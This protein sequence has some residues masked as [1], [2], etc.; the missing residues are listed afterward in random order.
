MSK[1]L[2]DILFIIFFVIFS[3]FIIWLP[4][5]LAL[6]NFWNLNFSQGFGTIYRNF[7]GLNYIIIAKTFYNP[8]LIAQIPQS[9]PIN[10]F[11]A[12]FPGYPLL[13]AIFAPFLGYLKS[14]LFVSILFTIVSAIAFYYLVKDFKLTS[15]PLLL[16]L[17]FLIIPARWLIIRS[18]GSP[19]PVFIFFVISVFYFLLKASQY[20]INVKYIWVSAVFA[21]LAQ[22]TRPPGALLGI[23][24]ALFVLWQGYKKK[25]I[26]YILSFYPF[27]L[28]PFTLLGIFWWY[29]QTLGDFWAYFHSGDNIHLIFP[30]FQ[31]FNI[32]QFWVGDIWLEDI[33]YIFL[34]GTLG[35][36]LLF[37]QKLYPLAFFVL[38]YF[39]ASFFIAHR[40]ISRY[41]LPAIPFVI[42]AFE[43]VLVSK[44]FKIV[45]IILTLAIYLY[46][47]NYILQNIAPVPD[48]SIYN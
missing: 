15:N 20:E 19:E 12:H 11:P 26:K 22:F 31:V 44:E 10:Y 18:I 38:T 30:P 17:V 33:V 1:T 35:G 27:L 28:I 9:L 8:D 4:H 6:P 36:L 3:T 47:Q 32:N 16:T 7:D 43:K 24:L 39:L 5:F 45:L 13:I 23:A 25:S 2:R 42:I 37:K 29:G 14:M 48:L 40:D 46:S 34:L 41:T 21:A